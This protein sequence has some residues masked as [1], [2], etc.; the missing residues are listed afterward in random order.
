MPEKY[1]THVKRLRTK[2]L[3]ACKLADRLYEL[4]K[5]AQAFRLEHCTV[6][7]QLWVCQSC[8]NIEYRH[9]ACRHRLCPIC[10]PK[11]AAEQAEKIENI[12]RHFSELKFITLTMPPASS[13][14]AGVTHIRQA[15]KVFRKMKTVAARM[16]GGAYKIEAKPKAEGKWHVHLHIIADCSY[17]PK[18]DLIKYWE[19]AVDWP[20]PSVDIQPIQGKQQI[21]DQTK[22]AAKSAEVLDWSTEQLEDYLDAMQNV[23]TLQTWGTFYELSKEDLDQQE[24][25]EEP[26]PC[27]CCGSATSLIPAAIAY[28]IDPDWWEAVKGHY[29]EYELYIWGEEFGECPHEKNIIQ[30]DEEIS[31]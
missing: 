29:E 24:P 20:K 2:H 7:K 6:Y 5:G 3:T 1:S 27:P 13:L 26:Q 11:R 22:Y 18:S 15:F 23:R 9:T 25:E 30:P 4:D 8:G 31:F 12:A 10:G 14:H 21:Q 17:F 28:F 16:R 19:I